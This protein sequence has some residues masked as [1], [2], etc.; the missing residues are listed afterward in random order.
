MQNLVGNE[1][2]VYCNRRIRKQRL[3]FAGEFISR[4]MCGKLI[5]EV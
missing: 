2:E 1:P 4:Q 3:N 5:R